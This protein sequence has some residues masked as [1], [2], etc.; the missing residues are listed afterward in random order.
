MLSYL[1][2]PPDCHCRSTAKCGQLPEQGQCL[3]FPACS[4]SLTATRTVIVL[5]GDEGHLLAV[6]IPAVH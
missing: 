2:P 6:F 3:M 1:R 5:G 4:V